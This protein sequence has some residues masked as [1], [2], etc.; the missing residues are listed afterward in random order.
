ME[1]QPLTHVFVSGYI[2]VSRVSVYVL[3]TVPEHFFSH[4][5]RISVSGIMYFH[6]RYHVNKLRKREI[7]FGNKFFSVSSFGRNIELQLATCLFFSVSVR[8]RS[9]PLH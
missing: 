6:N 5:R 8:F 2:T 7:T 9:F 1:T 3:S 4:F